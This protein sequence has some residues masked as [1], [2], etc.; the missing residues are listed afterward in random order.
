MTLLRD[1]PARTEIPAQPV[2][3]LLKPHVEGRHNDVLEPFG[4]HS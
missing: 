2:G 1:P 3:F 4:A